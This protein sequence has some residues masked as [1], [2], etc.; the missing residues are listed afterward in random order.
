MARFL[1]APETFN[2]GETSR[3]VEI[4]REL[5]SRG[6]A[7]HFTGYSTK[8][9]EFIRDNGFSLELLSPRLS[10][11]DAARM[12][13]F[14][15]GRSLRVP[16][17]EAVFRERV[18]SERAAIASWRPDAVII[19]TTVSQFISA[20]S[21]GVPL[22]YAR[23]YALSRGQVAAL[24]SFPVLSGTTAAT[25]AVNRLCGLGL[26]LLLTHLTW[27]PAGMAK[28]AAESNVSLGRTTLDVLS[29]DLN[30]MCSLEP[31]L[32]DASLGPTD[33]AVGPIYLRSEAEVPTKVAELAR[34]RKRPLVYV[35]MGS[36][37]NRAI[38][39]RVLAEVA[40]LDVDVIAPVKSYL[41]SSDIASL[42]PNVHLWDFLPAA[43]VNELVDAAVIHGGE[44]TVQTACRSGAPFA[45]IGL[46]PEQRYNLDFCVRQ[47]NALRFTARDLARGRLP[48]LV[49]QCLTRQ[50]LKTAARSMRD[51]T[52]QL[53]GTA[54]TADE[55]EAFIAR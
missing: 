7:I 40:K 8:Y 49:A 38:V 26:R 16:L 28:V 34:A 45:G 39:T 9:E 43:K 30:L 3:A 17:T 32:R 53:D 5:R 36:S 2:L 24:R 48:S 15:Q 29:A 18:R 41:H 14:D 35:A 13:D 37:G 20:R 22:I 19:G 31:V 11:R 55:I 50:D 46:Q 52:S 12:L 54:R 23:P 4:A 47:G 42:A 1:L 10:D 51:K 27:R 44:G 33:V 25:A 21:L 6:H